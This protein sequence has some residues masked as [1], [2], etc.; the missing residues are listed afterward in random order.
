[1]SSANGDILL[2]PFQFPKGNFQMLSVWFS[3]PTALTRIPSI[4]SI[5]NKSNESGHIC[6]VPDLRGKAFSFQS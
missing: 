4:L 6:L 5:L 1:M 2:L 3:S